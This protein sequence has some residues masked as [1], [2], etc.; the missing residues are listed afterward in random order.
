MSACPVTAED[1]ALA[2]IEAAPFSAHN[3]AAYMLPGGT[4]QVE[5]WLWPG[6]NPDRVRRRVAEQLRAVRPVGVAVA[7]VVHHEGAS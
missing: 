5:L 6:S 1:W 2:A 3:A 7:V 4:V